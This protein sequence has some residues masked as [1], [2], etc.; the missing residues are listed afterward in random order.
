MLKALVE[1]LLD[2]NKEPIIKDADGREYSRESLSPLPISAP[3]TLR[4]HTL[5]AII[6]YLEEDADDLSEILSP[7]IIHIENPTT[8]CL[9]SGPLGDFRQ[10]AKVMH[11]TAEI[12]EVPFG[13]V[14]DAESF[15]ITLQSM[16]VQT[17]DRK[18]ILE[19]VGNIREE[20][21]RNTTDDGIGQ[22]VTTRAGVSKV[23][24]TIVP[25]PVTLAPFRTFTEVPQHESAF[26]LRLQNG[27]SMALFEA[28]GGAWRKAAMT[29][30]KDY[31][32][33]QIEKRVEADVSIIS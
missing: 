15:N 23:G 9:Y 16:F 24:T 22:E 5:E 32:L 29:N 25:N 6:G 2:L 30:I 13:R 28:D 17:E 27:P 20:N 31:L 8:V 7:Y 21:V 1:Y 4:V 12:P 3:E 19:V 10:R 14:M 18:T 26:V 33:D 11:S